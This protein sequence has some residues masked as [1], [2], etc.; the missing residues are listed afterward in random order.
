MTM[1]PGFRKFVLTAHIASTVGWLGAVAAFLALAVVGVTSQDAQMVRA[2][3]I[4]NGLIGWYVILPLALASALIGVVQS[5]G[6][7]WGLIRHYW[8]LAKLLLTIFATIVLLVQMEAISYMAR[9]AAKVDNAGLGG[10]GLVVHAGGG[11]LVLLVI[12]ALSVYKPRGMTPY[13]WRKQ[14]EERRKRH[15]RSSL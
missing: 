3:W 13:G 6:T 9:E 2:A 5:L 8:V 7:E 4:A 11:L 14:Q 12:E 15:E 10:G 1:T